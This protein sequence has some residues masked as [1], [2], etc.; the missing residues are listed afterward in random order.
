[1]Q[2]SDMARVSSVTARVYLRRHAALAIGIGANLTIFGFAK[3]LLLARPARSPMPDRVGSRVHQSF[4]RDSTAE[5]RGV[6]RPQ[7]EL[8]GPGGVSR[9]SV[10]FG[11]KSRPSSCFA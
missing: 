9:R 10:N 3:E 7:S 6:S 4:F 1:M 2:T 5:L 11:L 8:C